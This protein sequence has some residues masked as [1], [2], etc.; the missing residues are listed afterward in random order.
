MKDYKVLFYDTNDDEFK[1]EELEQ[2]VRYWISLGIKPN[3]NDTLLADDEH[4]VKEVF[5]S[6]GLIQIR[7]R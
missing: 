2:I 3:I 1:D 7:F 5:Y 4:I 6:I